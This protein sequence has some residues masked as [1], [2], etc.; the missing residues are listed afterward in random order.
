MKTI[1]YQLRSENKL[2]IS[3]AGPRAESMRGYIVAL[4]SVIDQADSHF[5]Q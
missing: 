4:D 5:V 3:D 1:Q 2:R